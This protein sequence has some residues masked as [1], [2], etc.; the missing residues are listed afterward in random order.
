MQKPFSIARAELTRDLINRINESGIPPSVTADILAGL[1]QQAQ[2]AAQAQLEAD[3][4][5]WEAAQ[6]EADEET[7]DM[8]LYANNVPVGVVEREDQEEKEKDEKPED[9]GAKK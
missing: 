2:A 5:E 7:G 1:L 8:V 3:M 9:K 6:L 4:K